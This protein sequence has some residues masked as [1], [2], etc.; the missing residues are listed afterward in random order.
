MKQ[1]QLWLYISCVLLGAACGLVYDI[2]RALRRQLRH[3]LAAV[4][5][6]DFLFTLA[7]CAA[8][9]GLFFWKNQGTVRSYGLLGAACGA[10]LYWKTLS[11]PVMCVLQGLLRGLLY[12]VR[13]WKAWRKKRKKPLTKQGIWSKIK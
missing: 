2:F 8:G 13:R 5:I 7:V 9:Y 1:Q 12:P 4:L 11:L 6:E 3:N 10:L